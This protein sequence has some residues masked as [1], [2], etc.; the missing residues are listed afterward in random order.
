ML[1]HFNAACHTKE[2]MHSRPFTLCNGFQFFG[3]DN[4]QV[5]QKYM[6]LGS[7]EVVLW[8]TVP[9]SYSVLCPSTLYNVLGIIVVYV[10]HNGLFFIE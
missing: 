9:F 8:P 6:P 7:L 2:V 10:V 1:L 3:L 5:Y 4:V